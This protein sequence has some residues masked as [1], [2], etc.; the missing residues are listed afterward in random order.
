TTIPGGGAMWIHPELLDEVT[1]WTTISRKKSRGKT[2]QAN[3]IIASSIEPDS[4]VN[5]LTDSEEEEEVLAASVAGPLAAATRSGQPHLRN[6]N[7]SPVQQLEPS[8]EPV[9]EPTEH[10]KTMPE[11]PREVRY[12]RPLNNG[13]AVE[14][15]QPFRF[16]II[17]QLANIPARITLYEL[18]KLSKSTREALKEALAD[19]KVFVTQ[20]PIGS[21]IDEPH[22]LNVSCVPTDIVFTPEDMQ[23]QGRH[24]R[25]LYFTGY[26][27]STEITRIQVDL[28]STL[29]IMQRRVMEHLSIPAHR[30]SAT[31][32]DI[33]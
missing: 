16:D 30:L 31:H 13:K 29:S 27:G 32:I 10:P 12:N 14:V 6:Y 4:D 25:P 28:G 2:K 20:L 9:T 17:N 5:S 23:V 24:A 33:L 11:K 8:Q 21:T 18:L 26:I 7:D 3:V 15:S 19:A 1:P 22:S